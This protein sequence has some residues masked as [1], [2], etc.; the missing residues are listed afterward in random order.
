MCGVQRIVAAPADADRVDAVRR[1]GDLRGERQVRGGKAK[2]AAARVAVD[3]L[4]ARPRTAGRAGPRP[5]P[6]DPSPPARGCGR[7]T[8]ARR[9]ARAS[10]P[11]P[12]ASPRPWQAAGAWR[13]SRLGRGR[14]PTRATSPGRPGRGRAEA[15]RRSPRHVCS[16]NARDRN[17][18][19]TTKA[20][21]PLPDARELL[22][23]VTRKRR[24]RSPQN[25]VGMRVEGDGHGL[26]AGRCGGC[27]RRRQEHEL[28]AAVHAVEDAQR[29][30][31]PQ[32][33]RERVDAVDDAHAGGQ[34][35]AAPAAEPGTETKTFW[36]YR[37]PPSRR[38]IAARRPCS[39]TTRSRPSGPASSPGSRGAG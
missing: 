7:M 14:T 11:R 1:Q 25:G 15:A 32:P 6:D 38:A 2:L 20:I 31:E 9:P 5:P 30:H 29:G 36:G 21:R 33:G 4:A 19:P 24:R 12:A 27:A 39:S 28:M 13:R 17:A 23:R 18:A 16:E 26:R 22:G 8:R 3:H 37:R 10:A 35:T 34:E